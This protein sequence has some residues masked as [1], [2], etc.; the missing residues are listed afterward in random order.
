MGIAKY[1]PL[2]TYS[3][4]VK[5]NKFQ[6]SDPEGGH[7]GIIKVVDRFVLL[8]GFRLPVRCT[9]TGIKCGMTSFRIFDALL[10]AAGKF[11]DCR[12][13]EDYSFC[14]PPPFSDEFLLLS[15]IIIKVVRLEGYSSLNGL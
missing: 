1:D 13:R 15:Q 10:L 3:S 14:S 7:K 2:W 9:Q 6:E 8:S 4:M 12:G 11:I 5:I